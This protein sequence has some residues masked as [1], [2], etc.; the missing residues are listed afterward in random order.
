[1]EL[2]RNMVSMNP[3][4][5]QLLTDIS[6]F[7]AIRVSSSGPRAWWSGGRITVEARVISLLQIVHTGSGAHP[8]SYSAG[9]GFFFLRYSGRGM[10]LT[11]HLHP[12]A[13]VRMSGANICSLCI[14]SWRGEG[15]LHLY[16]EIVKNRRT[17]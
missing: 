15:N 5:W 16:T 1:M 3:A 8:V 12:V 17:C 6:K 7:M 9:P 10:T 4:R 14:P 13:R 11:A 2:V